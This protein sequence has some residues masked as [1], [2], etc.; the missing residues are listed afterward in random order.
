[1]SDPANPQSFNR[2]SYCLNNP[3]KYIDPSGHDAYMALAQWYREHGQDEPMPDELLHAYMV[4]SGYYSGHGGSSGTTPSAE[5]SWS[6][7]VTAYTMDVVELELM[8]VS[9]L[10]ALFGIMEFFASA[11]GT[12]ELLVASSY[13]RVWTSTTS[14]KG[15]TQLDIYIQMGEGDIKFYPPTFRGTLAPSQE[16]IEHYIS[17]RLDTRVQIVPVGYYQTTRPIEIHQVA[18]P[19][20]TWCSQ[21]SIFISPEDIIPMSVDLAFYYVYDNYSRRIW[22]DPRYVSISIGTE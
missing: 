14:T 21:G 20:G 15:G 13:C 17:Y 19:Q 16:T 11:S 8:P 18:G 1:M 5:P 3:L 7:W 4:G 22:M 10:W 2:Y 12:L 6:G 9:S